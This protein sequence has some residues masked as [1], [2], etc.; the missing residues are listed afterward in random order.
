MDVSHAIDQVR[1]VVSPVRLIEDVRDSVLVQYLIKLHE[2]D[3][4]VTCIQVKVAVVIHTEIVHIEA[5]TGFSESA[6]AITVISRVLVSELSHLVMVAVSVTVW[7]HVS[8]EGLVTVQEVLITSVLLEVHDIVVSLS[9][10]LGRSRLDVTSAWAVFWFLISS[11]S[12]DPLSSAIDSRSDR[13]VVKLYVDED[14]L[15]LSW[16][17]ASIW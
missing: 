15:L 17:S 3:A 16:S 1:F 2:N 12:R 5:I 7:S 9:H 13:L 4:S 8:N 10:E 6:N 14:D 11:K